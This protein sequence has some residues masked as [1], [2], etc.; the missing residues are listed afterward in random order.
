MTKRKPPV[1]PI[2]EARMVDKASALY[3]EVQQKMT[4]AAS[5]KF[6]EMMLFAQLYAG[7]MPESLAMKWANEDGFV[8]A[9]DALLKLHADKLKHGERPSAALTAFA[10]EALDHGRITRGRGHYRHDDWR[11]NTGIAVLVRFI[12]D[13]FGLTPCRSREQVKSR[14][15]ASFI[16][17]TALKRH[18][19]KR[20][21]EVRV[22]RIWREHQD[23]IFIRLSDYLTGHPD[24][25]SAP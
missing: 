12:C 20:M 15:S 17:A 18:G 16:V 23:D 25:A 7:L 4:S 22:E 19:L 5:A 2:D 24:F 10:T 1:T 14:P 21:D 6:L 9:S 11:R 3:L 8:P 13:E